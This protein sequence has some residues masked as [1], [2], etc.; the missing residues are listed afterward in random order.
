M[1]NIETLHRDFLTVER[2]IQRANEAAWSGNG[3]QRKAAIAW[4]KSLMVRRA[5]IVRAAGINA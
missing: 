5:A 2:L 4:K 1:S 3:S